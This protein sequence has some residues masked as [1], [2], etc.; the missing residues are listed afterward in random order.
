MQVDRAYSASMGGAVPTTPHDSRDGGARVVV[1][2]SGLAGLMAATEAASYAHE[3][4]VQLAVTVLEACPQ[5]GGNSA[6][7]SSGI[8]ALTPS[9]SPEVYA[10]DTLASGGGL[11]DQRL[12]QRLVVGDA[13]RMGCRPGGQACDACRH[14]LLWPCTLCY[15]ECCLREERAGP[16]ARVAGG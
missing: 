4:G 7:A 9:D 12:V 16:A 3:A 2:G 10:Q 15:R 8:N 5:V 13:L 6:K 14:F 1:I 11:S